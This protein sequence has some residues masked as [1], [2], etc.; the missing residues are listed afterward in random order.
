MIHPAQA[1]PVCN[2]H[3][4]IIF[5][6][7]VFLF[8]LYRS[9]FPNSFCAFLIASRPDRKKVTHLRVVTYIRGYSFSTPGSFWGKQSDTAS[10]SRC[11]WF[12]APHYGTRRPFLWRSYINDDGS[13]PLQCR[14]HPTA[15]TEREMSFKVGF[16][17]NEKKKPDVHGQTWRCKIYKIQSSTLLMKKNE[18]FR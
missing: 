11:Y 2:L 14:Q 1:I 18:R 16:F 10:S 5:L 15:L 4:R 12:S 13:T 7:G 8:V 3:T 9:S 17:S 6:Q